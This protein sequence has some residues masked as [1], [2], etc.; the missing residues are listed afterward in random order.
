M[1][2]KKCTRH[3]HKIDQST[4][5]P[6]LLAAAKQYNY[7]TVLIHGLSGINVDKDTSCFY[8]KRDGITDRVYQL[9]Q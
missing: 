7:C 5:N 8:T 4:L 2:K 3:M 1:I 9:I 6:K